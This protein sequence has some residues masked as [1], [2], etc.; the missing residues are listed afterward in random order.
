MT[1]KRRCDALKLGAL[2]FEQ[3]ESIEGDER[4]AKAD[5]NTTRMGTGA[6]PVQAPIQPV[7]LG[8]RTDAANANHGIE[9]PLTHSTHAVLAPKDA[10]GVGI[11]RMGTLVDQYLH[12]VAPSLSLHPHILRHD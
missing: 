12:S 11:A 1:R 8:F 9:L 4:S 5:W 10:I 7:A 6:H 2:I 3:Q